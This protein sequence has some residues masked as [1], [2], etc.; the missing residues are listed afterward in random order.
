MSDILRA[1]LIGLFAWL[2]LYGAMSPGGIKRFAE[3][4]RSDAQFRTVACFLV[5]VTLGG[6]AYTFSAEGFY[7]FV[8]SLA[9]VG[10]SV[11]A[12]SLW[13]HQEELREIK[14]NP[15]VRATLSCKQ[16]PLGNGSVLLSLNCTVRNTGVTP[17]FPDAKRG[18]FQI[19]RLD[20]DIKDQF[21]ATE[22]L[23]QK[24][25]EIGI[26]ERLWHVRLEPNTDTTF[27]A[28]YAA[29]PGY[30]YSILFTLP[31]TSKSGAEPWLWKKW[32]VI[33]VR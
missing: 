28:Y 27:T 15:G 2:C 7:Y 21:L 22:R 5:P 33:H 10:G 18:S 24:V 9:I 11:W 3:Q 31:D 23:G 20:S 17:I 26:P 30:L 19:G 12:A 1:L 8:A 14:E 13:M 29:A 6:V 4:W 16:T 32:R 25:A